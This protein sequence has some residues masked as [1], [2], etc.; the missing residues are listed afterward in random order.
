MPLPAPLANTCRWCGE[1]LA[2]G[3]YHESCESDFADSATY[4]REQE[5]REWL[6]REAAEADRAEWEYENNVG[7]S[8][9]DR[10]PDLMRSWL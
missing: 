9:D 2:R 6:A 1:S 10:E 7:E 8:R 4:A 3:D 5:R